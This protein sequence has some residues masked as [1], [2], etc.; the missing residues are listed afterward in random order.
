MRVEIFHEREFLLFP[1]YDPFPTVYGTFAWR[2]PVPGGWLLGSFKDSNCDIKDI[3]WAHLLHGTVP[4]FA[5]P[6]T[7]G[8]H[9]TFDANLCMQGPDNVLIGMR[10][11]VGFENTVFKYTIKK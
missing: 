5:G 6:F 8:F 2:R 9:S 10:N 3:K 7:R 1:V 11:G 4:S